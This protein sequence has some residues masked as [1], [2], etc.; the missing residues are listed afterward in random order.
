MNWGRLLPLPIV[1]IAL[2]C[3]DLEHF[4][5]GQADAYCGAITL[6]GNFRMG[7]SPRVQMR[8]KLE[9]SALDGPGV[10]GTISTFEMTSPEHERRLLTD[11][12]LRRLP[13]MAHDPLSRPDFGDGR[14]RNW[15]FAVS[16]TD[17][18]AE[19]LISV[20]SLRADDT[21]E[22]RLLRPGK[23]PQGD[24]VVAEGRRPL[25]GI[26]SLSRQVGT[27]GF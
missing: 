14:I 10:P 20:L 22:V 19:S 25:F 27:C 9:A 17:P 1:C 16:P 21:V 23:A 18:E 24:E 13:A 7:L 15:I 3:T 12:E 2:S 5:T 26:F 4:S 6:G 8:L 11:A